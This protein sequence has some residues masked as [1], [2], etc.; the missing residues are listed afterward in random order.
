MRRK[1][2]FLVNL[3]VERLRSNSNCING[4]VPGKGY[5]GKGENEKEKKEGKERQGGKKR[6]KKRT[7]RIERGKKKRERERE[8]GA[9]NSTRIDNRCNAMSRNYL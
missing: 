1:K 3:F 8:E 2:K 9:L 5:V 7:R 6:R 4:T